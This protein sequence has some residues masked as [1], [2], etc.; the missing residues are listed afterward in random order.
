MYLIEQELR[1]YLET[2]TEDGD[3]ILDGHTVPAT[4]E[5]ITVFT[6]QPTSYSRI[7][8]Q[9]KTNTGDVKA[10][11]VIINGKDFDDED[12][13]ETLTFVDN[14]T[15]ARKTNQFFKSVTNIV[16]PVQD[17]STAT[18]DIGI[19]KFTYYTGKCEV[20]H[21]PMNDLP[22]LMIYG[23]NTG[24]VSEQLSTGRDKFRYNLKVEVLLNNFQY[25]DQ[26]FDTSK[27]LKAQRELKILMEEKDTNGT[28]RSS[29]IL[30]VLRRNITGLE[31]LF[32]ND[33]LIEYEN[34]NINDTIYIRAILTVAATTKYRN[35]S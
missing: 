10:G 11:N 3:L 2:A 31:Y 14:D 15:L 26:N 19:A 18:W 22:V 8:I 33:I 23:E 32:N 13:S 27:I 28:P 12:I 25:T 16:F 21:I 17:G 1:Q 5:T 30:G 9:P 20:N 6:A 24:L 4:G 34:E 35:R 29:S 7:V